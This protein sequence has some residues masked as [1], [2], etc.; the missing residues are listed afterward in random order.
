MTAESEKMSDE[1]QNSRKNALLSVNMKQL[2][3]T[4]RDNREQKNFSKMIQNFEDLFHQEL[5]KIERADK[6]FVT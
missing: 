3:N 5:A 1:N 6:M 2:M 4:M